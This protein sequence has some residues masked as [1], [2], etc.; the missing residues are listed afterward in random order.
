MR[1][2]SIHP[3]YLDTK[4]LVALWRETLLAKNVLENRTKGY[5][6]H[7]QLSRFKISDQPLDAINFYLKIVYDEALMRNYNFD[8]NKIGNINTNP[9][10]PVTEGQ[11]RYEFKHLMSKLKLR[12]PAGYKS[13]SK[14]MEPEL[15]PLF[16]LKK[17]DI[18]NWEKI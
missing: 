17:G 11:V 4:G 9:A 18:E 15:H 10:L 1:I 6:N 14:I 12:D 13:F 2:W 8:K 7:P 3:R 16:I 5:R